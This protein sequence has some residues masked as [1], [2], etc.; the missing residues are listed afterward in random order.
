[1]FQRNQ[2]KIRHFFLGDGIANL[3]CRYR[4]T[5]MKL[6]G[7]EGGAMDSVFSYSTAGHYNKITGYDFLDMGWLS[8][9][10]CRII[11]PVPQ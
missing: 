3:Y 2:K 10:E 5:F 6:F 8:M 4:G 1:M 11:P 9:E 7:R